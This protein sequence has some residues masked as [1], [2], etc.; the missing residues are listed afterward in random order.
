MTCQPM[1]TSTLCSSSVVP[2]LF[3]LST[4]AVN[5]L[6]YFLLSY[7]VEAFTIIICRCLSCRRRHH[8]SH[9]TVHRR[10]DVS[11]R[12]HWIRTNDTHVA[13][14][15]W[16]PAWICRI[17]SHCRHGLIFVYIGNCWRRCWCHSWMTTMIQRRKRICS[18]KVSDQKSKPVIIRHATDLHTSPFATNE[19]EVEIL[20][21][22]FYYHTG[23]YLYLYRR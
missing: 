15:R 9:T 5:F 10:C 22:C 1:S 16:H 19:F 2:V 20:I 12:H 13:P 8:R 11:G 3:L 17:F 23:Q 21:V 4:A 7:F 6:S 14:D 18:P